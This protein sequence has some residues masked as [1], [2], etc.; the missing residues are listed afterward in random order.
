MILGLLVLQAICL[1]QARILRMSLRSTRL[2]QQ[3]LRWTLIL[4][5]AYHLPC[6]N[7]KIDILALL[8]KNRLIKC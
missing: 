1:L 7:G 8:W 2:D 5:A 4:D 3:R 6:K